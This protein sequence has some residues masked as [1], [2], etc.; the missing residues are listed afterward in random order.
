MKQFYTILIMLVFIP[1][2]LMSNTVTNTVTPKYGDWDFQIKEILKLDGY[3]DQLLASV[4]NFAVHDDGRIFIFDRTHFKFIVFNHTGKLLTTFGKRGEGPGEIKI[5]L[6]FYLLKDRLIAYDF[7]KIHHLSLDGKL[8]R[9]VPASSTIGIAPIQF[10]DENRFV[11]ARISFGRGLVSPKLEALE[12]YD[13]STEKT[14]Y[15]D[16]K[17]PEPGKGGPGGTIMVSIGNDRLERN[18]SYVTGQYGKDLL[19][20]KND[21]YLIHLCSTTGKKKITFSI[22]GKERSPISMALKERLVSRMRVQVSG[23]SQEDLKKRLINS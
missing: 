2:F 22:K 19:W 8:I 3:G 11:K 9:T 7:G 16:G 4:Q 5:M 12:L 10:L 18:T 1:I 20:G 21:A 15:L 14:V 6:N 13:T 23:M 17:A